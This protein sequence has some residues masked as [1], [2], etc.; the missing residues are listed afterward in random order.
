MIKSL[1]LSMATLGPAILKKGSASELG[2]RKN[3]GRCWV[4]WEIPDSAPSGGP[5]QGAAS[6]GYRYSENP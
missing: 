6:I 5:N 2:A 3:G 4:D 1:F